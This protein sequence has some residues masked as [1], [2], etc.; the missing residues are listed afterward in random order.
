M[1]ILY[2]LIAEHE[3]TPKALLIGIPLWL[4]G[5]LG[6]GYTMKIVTNKT[7]R[8]IRQKP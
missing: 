8:K 2:P 6:W 4:I 1:E 5:G 3:I 7:E